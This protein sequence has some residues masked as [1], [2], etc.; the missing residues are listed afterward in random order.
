M[1]ITGDMRGVTLG[2][3][4]TV[5]KHRHQYRSPVIT[6]NYLCHSQPTRS[7]YVPLMSMVRG[8][9]SGNSP[10]VTSPCLSPMMGRVVV[11]CIGGEQSQPIEFTCNTRCVVYTSNTSIAFRYCAIPYTLSFNTKH[12]RSDLMAWLIIQIHHSATSPQHWCHTILTS[13]FRL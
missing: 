9:P 4:E 2:R 6:H 13:S 12:A 5:S 3:Q 1:D 8:I 7:R 11:F 10:T